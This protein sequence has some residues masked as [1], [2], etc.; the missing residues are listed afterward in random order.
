MY[1]WSNPEDDAEDVD[2]A[3]DSSDELL[4]ADK[5]TQEEYDALRARAKALL[6]KRDKR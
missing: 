1:K 5:V 2:L 3:P 4:A 6:E